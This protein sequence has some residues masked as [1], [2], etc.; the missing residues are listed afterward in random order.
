MQW[1]P[2]SHK[3]FGKKIVDRVFKKRRF[4]LNYLDVLIEPFMDYRNGFFIEVGANDGSRQS[5]TRYF[6][7]YKGW[8]GLLIEAIPDLAKKC[9]KNRPRSIVEN[10]ALVSSDY[11][12]NTIDIHYCNLMSVIK[13][14]A[15][16]K[17]EHIANGKRFLKENEADEIYSVPAITLDT[18]LEKHNIEEIDLLSL[19]VEGY[20]LEVLK[21]LD[22]NRFRPKFMLIEVRDEIS[23]DVFLGERYRKIAA[24]H[25]E[26]AYSDILYRSV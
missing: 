26:E 10:Y 15:L 11:R 23:V 22:L 13:N 7:M 18:L 1:N 4:A 5:N 25:I 16:D 2:E 19:D 20:E 3:R 9:K 21:G 14:S 12:E 8:R 24:L 17:A 6:E